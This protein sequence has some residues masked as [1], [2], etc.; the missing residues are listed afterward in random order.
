MFHD[1]TLDR[2]TTGAGLIRTQPWKGVVEYVTRMSV[3]ACRLTNRNVRTKKEPV[4]PI[5]LFE[6]LV[7]LLMEDGNK[8]VSLNV[9]DQIME[10]MLTAKID[11]KIQ[12]D[13][14]KLFVCCPS[15][16]EDDLLTVSPRWHASS[17]YTK[18]GRPN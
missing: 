1:P 15:Q 17:R 16:Q 10:L 9:S 4:Q 11:C 14:E 8:H 13:P 3:A 12:N 7:A 6:E 18:T 2:T 5:P